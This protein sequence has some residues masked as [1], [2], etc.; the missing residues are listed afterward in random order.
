MVPAAEVP[1]PDAP[2][3]DT[4]RLPTDVTPGRYALTIAPDIAA[5]T[6]R[7]EV[8]IEVHVHRATDH[9]VCNAA[10][11]SVDRAWIEG[12]TGS[13]DAGVEFDD[14]AE[15]VR[16]TFD[17]VLPPGDAVL[18]IHFDGVL[19]DKL[20][21]FYRSTYTDDDGGQHTIATTQFEATDARRAFP[22][23][24]EPA[25]KAV[26]GV[27]LLV[28][29]DL[30]AVSNGPELHRETTDDG[31]VRVTF[32]DTMPMST[33]LVAFVVG[34][35]EATAPVDVDGIPLRIVHRPGQ[36]DLTTFALEVGAFA[37]RY[38]ADYYG[39][40]YPGDKMDMVAV[41]DFAFGA[42]ENLGC[43]TYREALLLVDPGTATQSELLSVVDVIAHEL[44]HMW[45]GDLV[46]MS[47]W[48]GIWLN[49]AFATFMEMK[50]SEAFRPEWERWM[51]F[52]RERTA[53]FDTDALTSTRPIEFPVHSPADAEGMFDV[54]TYQ[55]GSAVVRMLEQYLGED[56]FRDGIRR[57]LQTH[58]FGNTETGDL[59][60]ALEAETGE[61]VRTMMDSWIFQGG[62]PLL[63]VKAAGEGIVQINQ[64][65][66]TFLASDED[67]DR[68][69]RWHV[70]VVVRSVDGERRVVL[71]DAEVTVPVGGGPVMVNAG[72]HGFYRAAYDTDLHA[73]LLAGLVDLAPLER[74]A[75]LDDTL[76]LC[77][78]GAVSSEALTHLVRR[79]VDVG[80]RDHSIWQLAAEALDTLGRVVPAADRDAWS[81]WVRQT[82]RPLWD[83]LGAEVAPG[84]SDRRR[85]LR[86]LVLGLL[87]GADDPEAVEVSAELLDRSMADPSS[88]DSGLASGALITMAQHAD[89]ARFEA[90]IGR[91]RA[92]ETPQLQIRHLYAAASVRDAGLFDRYLGLLT[93]DE[94]RSQ[95]LAF[96]YRAALRN[97]MHGITAWR[98]VRDRWDTIVD[99]LPFNSLHRLVEGVTALTDADVAAEISEFLHAH[100]IPQ[101]TKL[102]EQHIERM[103][104]TVALRERVG[105][106][107]VA[108]LR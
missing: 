78:S 73:D 88:V 74:Y 67:T 11:L 32:A 53:A 42:M 39:I 23:W 80:E 20:R 40:V 59:W 72:G 6:F 9:I 43:V 54:L 14:E 38:F 65:P 37:L 89:E 82:V 97:P 98:A 48:N 35:L 1:S 49:E 85:A 95:N 17:H 105:D 21:G 96:A 34:P 66:F 101:A 93:G 22:C 103:R 62:F 15:Q 91:F 84:D 4:F 24:D 30:L 12:A 57:Y 33:Y 8:A 63:S 79:L 108:E 76:A 13:S 2:A 70:P 86:G 47:W 5:A 55:K 102:V 71:D 75:V 41:P 50:C 58:Q 56:A 16:F 61:P 52:G 106:R 69:R 25:H 18:H 107:V 46:T 36:A 100:P 51:H 104:V 83:E 19:N 7:G 45:F 90:I 77:L 10:E 44:A 99:R 94:I 92:G 29:D 68:T 64:E 27:T 87:G 28:A 60:D 31:R 26:F 3:P 81:A